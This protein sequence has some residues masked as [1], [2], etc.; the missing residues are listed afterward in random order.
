MYQN[1][2]KKGVRLYKCHLKR[3]KKHKRYK[4]SEK[5]VLLPELS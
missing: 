4:I 3:K 2:L 1:Y 5:G